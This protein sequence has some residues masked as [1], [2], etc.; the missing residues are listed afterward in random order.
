MIGFVVAHGRSGTTWVAHAI[1]ECSDISAEHESMG[2]TIL[3]Q[4]DEVWRDGRCVSKKKR[5]KGHDG[6]EVNGNLWNEIPLIYGEFPG[7]PVVHLVRDGRKVV[8][9]ALSNALKR[10][11]H[12]TVKQSCGTWAIRND[13]MLDLVPAEFRFRLEDLVSDFK[14]FKTMCLI[15]GATKVS[16]AKWD[17]ARKSIRNR[18]RDHVVPPFEKWSGE[19]QATFWRVC[20]PIMKYLEYGK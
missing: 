15:F 19:D 5:E 16:R 17:A 7:V 2:H 3:T 20:G 10:T 4:Y 1:N 11:P 9:S 13:R 8:R 12:R 14:E 18:T 6:V